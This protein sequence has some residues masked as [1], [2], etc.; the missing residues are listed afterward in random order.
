M[1]RSSSGTG[2]E[3]KRVAP[4]TVAPQ[5]TGLPVGVQVDGVQLR[6]F[7]LPS[8]ADE[9]NEAFRAAV[10]AAVP[11]PLAESLRCALREHGLLLLRGQSEGTRIASELCAFASIFCEAGA[12]WDPLKAIQ[13][14]INGGGLAGLPMVRALGTTGSAKLCRMGYEWHVDSSDLTILYCAETPASGGETL[15][16]DACRMYEVLSDEQ[17][18]IADGL[19]VVYSSRYSAGGPAWLD[20]EYGLRMNP[21]GTRL[22]R[23]A[24]ARKDAWVLGESPPLPAT[25]ERNGRRSLVLSPKNIDYIEGYSHEASQALVHDLLLAG[26]GPTEPAPLDPVSMLPTGATRFGPG[27]YEH[28]WRAGDLVVWDNGTVAHSTTPVALYGEGDRRMLQIMFS[29]ERVLGE[30]S[31]AGCGR[32]MNPGGGQGKGGPEGSL[33]NSEGA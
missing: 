20:A 21:T 2:A 10:Q 8:I 22:L 30:G 25:L 17:R 23:A 29:G 1:K 14:D 26:L 24:T 28:Q 3:A 9:S 13:F 11:R 32:F 5:L 31:G 18:A 7:D 12:L 4:Q 16:A 15:F 19:K 27:V 6:T 33:P